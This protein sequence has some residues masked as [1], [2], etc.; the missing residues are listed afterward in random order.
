MVSNYRGISLLDVLSK[1]LERQ[2]YNEILVLFALFLRTGSMVSCQEN[3]LSQLSRVVHQ[4]AA[5]LER[6]QQVDVIYLDFSKAFD[7]L[8]HE[9]RL[10]KLES[11]GIG[12]CLLAWFQSYLS[13]RRHRVVIDNESADFLPVAP[14]V[15]QGSISG[16]LL[17]LL[18][19]Q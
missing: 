8:S 3:P 18:F 7:R 4:F 17:F 5:A 16:P 11:L 9:K 12:G 15:S 2:V 13:G 1:N 6:R 19:Y 10:F 14:G